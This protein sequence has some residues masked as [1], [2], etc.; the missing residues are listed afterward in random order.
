MPKQTIQTE[1]P[2]KGAAGVAV[3]V[4]WG[5]EADDTIQ[6]MTRNIEA[7]DIHS[8]EAGWAAHLTE[9]QSSALIRALQRAHRKQFLTDSS[10]G[11]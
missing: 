11:D 6:I 4:N 2:F 5:P 1:P 8:P 7:E 3:D 9:T 10:D